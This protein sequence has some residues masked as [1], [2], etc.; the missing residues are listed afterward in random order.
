MTVKEL[1]EF[2]NSKLESGD[3][4]PEDEILVLT[5]VE[6]M[7]VFELIRIQAEKE[8]MD[9]YMHLGKESVI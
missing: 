9:I 6:N 5:D 7:R 2:F 1:I 4:L 8:M 3:I